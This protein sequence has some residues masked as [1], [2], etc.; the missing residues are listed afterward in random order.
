MTTSP[1]VLQKALQWNEQDPDPET[2]S[3]LADIIQRARAGD[4][5]ALNDLHDR[6][7][8]RLT[9]GTAGLRGELAAGSNRMNRVL[10]AQTA[11]GFAR[12]LLTNI[13]EPEITIVI[14]YDGR[15]NSDI[16]A[17]DTAEI[18]SAIG[19]QALVLPKPI[20]TPVLAFAIR[21]LNTSAGIMVTASH[22]PPNDNGYK[23]Y[24]GGDHSGSQIIPPVDTEIAASIEAASLED[25][26][27]IP[28]S[29][30]YRTLD[31]TIEQ[32][33]IDATVAC[34]PKAE[35][36]P[37]SCVYTAMH[38]VGWATL[39][40][41]LTTAGFNKPIAVPEQRDPHPKF[42]TV[43]FPNP[44]EPGAL[45]LAYKTAR[46]HNADIILAND[47]DA[48]RLAVALPDANRP[49]GYRRLTG[50]E[51][52]LLL[53]W[54]IAQA[55]QKNNVKG[56]FSCSIVSSPALKV[57]AKT[58][59]LNF[60]PSLTG[61]KWV[62]RVPNLIFGYEEAL[63]YLVNPDTVRDK[64]GISAAIAFLD[65]VSELA[66]QGQTVQDAL[67]TFICR[68][69]AYASDQISLR[70]TD[71][72]IISTAMQNIRAQLPTSI[73]SIPVE[74][75]EDLYDP[76][77]ASPNDVISFY[78]ADESRIMIRPSGTEPKLKVYVDV[79]SDDGTLQERQQHVEKKLAS[80]NSGIQTLIGQ[81]SGQPIG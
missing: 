44:E 57:L 14:G 76:L 65:M 30:Q 35:R 1:D 19:I 21:H 46:E 20:A 28:R 66:K 38:G 39:E 11:L 5:D 36:A 2:Q 67:D 24:L 26:R 27:N 64:D 25:I 34:I 40:K 61:F 49:E 31:D 69:G 60:E 77:D 37:I 4:S 74:Q 80:M 52:G 59:G 7:D 53:G 41:V 33:Y 32:A 51:V 22:N 70:V 68:F 71:L 58:Y 43:S 29:E 48:D 15:K 23:V 3:E 79:F 81:A 75:V 16:F 54:W 56:T 8:T 78:L 42:P 6:F 72:S 62:S 45:D 13:T 9:F 18:M 50:N 63:G 10:I 17:K 12:W 47:P 55:A 73:N